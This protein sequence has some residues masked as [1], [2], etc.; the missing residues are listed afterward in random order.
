VTDAEAT[1]E[2]TKL[3]EQ[4]IALQARNTLRRTKARLA[5]LPDVILYPELKASHVATRKRAAVESV[6][7]LLYS[8][9][10]E[11]KRAALRWFVDADSKDLELRAKYEKQGSAYPFEALYEGS[12]LLGQCDH[13][14]GQLWIKAS[15]DGA[16]LVEVAAHEAFHH[17]CESGS[18]SDALAFGRK[19]ASLLCP[20]R[21]LLFTEA[22][23]YN[24]KAG[25]SILVP[26]G[27]RQW[28]RIL[29][30][31]GSL[32]WHS[33]LE[34]YALFVASKPNIYQ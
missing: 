10:P 28:V 15:L 1:Q 23:R 34:R 14:T 32:A 19:A 29:G 24:A 7:D 12:D 18:E 20:Q 8:Q 27:D 11:L 33:V 6:L 2:I 17:I 4:F 5:A 21:G 16:Q 13:E 3:Y 22:N 25:D 26:H 30:K 9:R 31:D